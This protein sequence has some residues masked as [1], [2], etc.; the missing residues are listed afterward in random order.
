VVG[1]DTVTMDM[2]EHYFT[3][4]NYPALLEGQSG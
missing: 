1:G 3:G 2:D 4:Q